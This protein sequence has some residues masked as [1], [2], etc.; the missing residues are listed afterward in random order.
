VTL[1]SLQVDVWF[2][3]GG[4]GVYVTEGVDEGVI[5]SVRVEPDFVCT[6]GVGNEVS[7]MDIRGCGYV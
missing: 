4:D 6:Y 1:Y 3:F 7:I 2:W 5:V